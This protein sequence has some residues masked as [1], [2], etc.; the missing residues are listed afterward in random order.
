[1]AGTSMRDVRRRI[2]SVENT[3]QITKAMQLVAASKLRRAK[4]RVETARPYFTT[5]YDTIRALSASS[6][7]EGGVYTRQ[8][9]VRRSAYLVLG[10]DRG[11]AGGY[12][13]NLFRFA[14]EVMDPEAALVVP[15]GKRAVDH[16]SRAP[17]EVRP[18]GGYTELFRSGE[19]DEGTFVYTE[20]RSMLS[21]VPVVKKIL[22]L[23]FEDEEDAPAAFGAAEFDPSPAA[24]LGRIIPQYVGGMVFGAMSEAFASEQGARRMAMENAS[25]NAEEMIASLSLQ[26]N[27]ARQ[28]AITQEIT[29]ISSGFEAL[30]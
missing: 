27:R 14:E 1:M 3:M 18:F 9:P 23:S 13:A 30:R 2:H 20:F 17:Y 21:Q 8:R 10:G 5:L 6:A 11:L 26:Y 25:D 12:N 24:V 7:G 22:P 4:E 28:G 29:E 19:V 16:Y 15:V